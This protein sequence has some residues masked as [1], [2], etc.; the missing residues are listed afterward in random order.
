MET[1]HQ[2]QLSSAALLLS[3]YVMHDVCAQVDFIAVL[4]VRTA[5]VIKNLR[6]GLSPSFRADL[7][8]SCVLQVL[9]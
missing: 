3:P 1:Y 9:S 7:L 8:P 6:S 2:L 5:D 4:F